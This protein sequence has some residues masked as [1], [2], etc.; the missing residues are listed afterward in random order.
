[1]T[2]A[3]HYSYE[4]SNGSSVCPRISKNNIAVAVL[5]GYAFIT[6]RYAFKM[7]VLFSRRIFHIVHDGAYRHYLYPFK[8]HIEIFNFLPSVVNSVPLKFR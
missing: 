4:N 8:I 6:Q 7:V 2:I 1:M 5:P 3:A